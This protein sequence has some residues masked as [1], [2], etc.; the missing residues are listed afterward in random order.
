MTACTIAVQR[1]CANAFLEILCNKTEANGGSCECFYEK[2]RGDETPFAK[3]SAH[4]DVTAAE[5]TASP[6]EPTPMAPAEGAPP[7]ALA[8]RKSQTTN[9]VAQPSTWTHNVA[10][11]LKVYSSD[12]EIGALFCYPGSQLLA[13]FKMICPL[14]RMDRCKAVVY[15]RMHLQ[16]SN[17]LPVRSRF[18]RTQRIHCS[19]G[20]AALNL[21]E[22]YL[23][24]T[25]ND[26]TSNYAVTTPSCQMR[27]TSCVSLHYARRGIRQQLHHGANSDG[28]FA[29]RPWSFCEIQASVLGVSSSQP[30]L[31]GATTI[32]RTWRR[33]GQA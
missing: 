33:R 2:H 28:A 3:V 1:C 20:D 9:A 11:N 21:A 16:Q 14:A 12:L 27:G 32:P 4:D 13:T 19:D 29:E 6:L 24:I 26:E 23:N 17:V 5:P 7:T 22:Q 10:A 25:L 31:R 15:H 30:H 8:T 18:K